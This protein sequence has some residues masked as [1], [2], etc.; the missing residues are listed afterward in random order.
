[1]IMNT[2]TN[3]GLNMSTLTTGERMAK[4]EERTEHI[5]DKVDAI[6]KK[7]DKFIESAEGRFSARWVQNA[8]VTIITTV[9][10]AVLGAIIGLVIIK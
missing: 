6:D 8:M 1:M 9:C 7:L 5:Q 4:L 10:L 3:I 2:K